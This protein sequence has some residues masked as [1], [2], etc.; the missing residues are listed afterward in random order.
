MKS[1]ACCLVIVLS[2]SVVLIYG[3][4][5]QWGRR[6]SGDRLLDYAVVVNNSLPV[7]EKSSIYRYL[8]APGAYR[9][10]NITAIYARD[11]VPA[12][13]GGYAGI[14]SGGVNQS[15]V[16]L[17]LTSKPYLRFNFTVEVYGK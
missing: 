2:V 4:S 14:V 3:E 15:N 9:P 7:P 16:T 13:N 1:I 12:G 17:K 8:P 10:P 6:V 5:R 11:N